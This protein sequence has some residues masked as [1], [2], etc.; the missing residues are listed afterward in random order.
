MWAPTMKLLDAK[1]RSNSDW[2]HDASPLL[3]AF[4][5]SRKLAMVS[6]LIICLVLA[7]P[8]M[9]LGQT[10]DFPGPSPLEAA[11]VLQGH[12]L[13]GLRPGVIGQILT[14][15]T[16]GEIGLA[17]LPIP[18]QSQEEGIEL[19]LLVEIDGADLLASNQAPIPRLEIY[20]YVL[21]ESGGIAAH[22]AQVFAL[23]TA[24]LGEVVWQSGLKFFGRLILAPGHYELRTLVRNY[25]S[26]AQGLQVVPFV[27]PDL[28]SARTTLLPP[29][30][31]GP[32]NRDSWLPVS[33]LKRSS[34]TPSWSYPFVAGSSVVD[35]AALPV[36][37]AGIDTQV[38]LFGQDIPNGK[39]KANFRRTDKSSGETELIE[40]SRVEILTREPGSD[41]GL[42]YVIASFVAPAI[43][44]GR[45]HFDLSFAEGAG[46]P[47]ISTPIPILLVRGDVRE[48]SLIWSDLRHMVGRSGSAGAPTTSAA[49]SQPEGM[50]QGKQR[51]GRA[52][53]RLSKEY[54]QVLALLAE[55]SSESARIAL[56][57]LESSALESD[58]LKRL[59]ATRGA[60]LSTAK[61]LAQQN[62]DVL[63]P[64]LML[65]ADTHQL[66][67]SRRLYSLT[68]HAKAMVEILAELYAELGGSAA[69]T[70]KIMAS[71]AG[72]LQESNLLASSQRLYQRGLQHDPEAAAALLGLAATFEKYGSYGDAIEVLERLVVADPD[73]EEARLRLAINL[74]RV[75]RR[76]RAREVLL[77]IIEKSSDS[78]VSAVAHQ[79][80]AQD[81]LE[82]GGA[83]E[84]AELLRQAIEKTPDRQGLRLLLAHVYDRQGRPRLAL[85]QLQQVAPLTET[86]RNSERFTYD[87]WPTSALGVAR[88]EVASEAQAATAE[89]AKL[90][91]Q[92][93]AGS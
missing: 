37:V 64:I 12:E 81:Y 44:P 92:P 74:Q 90:L 23:E 63:L 4:E 79:E 61:E 52:A 78:W 87:S 76:P 72:Y 27:V 73:Q 51:L 39:V 43:D 62:P 88:R 80:M 40:S 77:S 53:R 45:F 22:L 86:T 29:L 58:K 75:G 11:T 83:D 65:H 41:S 6:I 14:G 16:G 1:T 93:T 25:H 49:V 10:E 68:F 48:K 69:T 8:V 2:H 32:Q 21:D 38:Y 19:L 18:T 20:A 71:Q 5:W 70:A 9:S 15:E 50:R 89:L 67:R 47:V 17:V 28:A 82:T 59:T 3:A 30:F 54:R 42:E 36:V 26:G 85:E 35:P 84:A 31:P 60:E 91:A 56:F 57:E 13:R 66:Y 24:A 33:G 46:G 55:G 34:S 7:W